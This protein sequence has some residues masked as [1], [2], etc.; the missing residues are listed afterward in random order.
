MSGLIETFREATVLQCE[1]LKK[2]QDLDMADVAAFSDSMVSFLSPTPD[3]KFVYGLAAGRS[4]LS[5]YSFLQLI[6]N[7]FTM[8][9]PSPWRIPFRGTTGRV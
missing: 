5:L 8:S 2:L 7:H 1:F 6:Q 4:A 3:N 9:S